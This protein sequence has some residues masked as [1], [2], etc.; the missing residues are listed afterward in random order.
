MG[1]KLKTSQVN[2]RALSDLI[3]SR[4]KVVDSNDSLW[5]AEVVRSWGKGSDGL[6]P[7]NWGLL[8]IALT[9]RETYPPSHWAIR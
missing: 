5:N 7:I 6:Q 3:K 2:F 1:Q 4:I 8:E 9:L